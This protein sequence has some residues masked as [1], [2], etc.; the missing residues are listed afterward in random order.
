MIGKE[1]LNYTVVSFLGKGG[2]GS[3]YLGEHKYIKNQKVAIKVI[4][5]EMVN[6]FTKQRLE[7]EAVHLASLSHQ[8]IVHFQDY[9]IDDEGNLY[10]IIEYADGMTLDKYIQN[11]SGLIVEDRICELFEPILD[12]V[13]FAHK[14]KVVHLDIKPANIM[15]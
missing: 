10:L 7:K 15:E 4:N 13:G 8:N 11:V 6:S 14:H 2:M 5:K 12:A 9:H 3:V 1:I